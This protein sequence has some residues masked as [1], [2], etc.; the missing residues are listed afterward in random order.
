[1]KKA[2][3]P[4][5]DYGDI[6][7]YISIDKKQVL[8]VPRT[9]KVKEA[10]IWALLPGWIKNNIDLEIIYLSKEEEINFIWPQL[11]SECASKFSFATNWLN[12]AQRELNDGILNINLESKIAYKKL[13]SRNFIQFLEQRI[14]YYTESE[15]TVKPGNGNFVRDVKIEKKKYNFSS[16]DQ[17]KNKSAADG[18]NSGTNSIICGQKINRDD[19]HSLSQIKN[20]KSGV[21]IS[22]Y[23]FDQKK[24]KTRS[25]KTLYTFYL[26]D[27]NDSIT[28]KL[29]VNQNSSLNTRPDTGD[30]VK[31]KGNIKYDTY[32]NELT[33][34][35]NNMQKLP[36]EKRMDETE[37]TRTELHL[38]TRMSAMD[39]VVD[40]EK[41]I[42]TAA[43]WGHSALAI[44]DHGVVQAFPDAYEAGQKH[45]IKIIYGLEAYM[46][47]DGK[48]IIINSKEY[49]KNAAEATYTVFDLETTG[50]KPKNSE[51]IE[52]GAVKIQQGEIIDKF[53]TFVKP[54]N[55]IP[56]QIT[57]ITGI[58]N[59]MVSDAPLIAQVIEDFLEFAD[60]TVLVA[61]NADFDYGFLLK[62]LESGD[63]Y[64]VLDTLGLSRALLPELKS[65]SLK[66]LVS[67]FNI[68]L[69]NHHR[70]LDDA[71][72]TGEIFLNLMLRVSE[73][74]IIELED[75]NR[76]ILESDW[77]DLKP[78]HII[79][80]AKNQK[81]LKTLYKLVSESHI[82]YFHRKPRILKSK[83]IKNKE[84]L[85][86]GS[87]CESGQLF[88]SILEN[89][90]EREIKKLAS[91]Y[92]YLEIQP[93]DNNSFLVPEQVSTREELK[94]INKKIYQ[95]GKKM[96]LPVVATCDVH[97]ENPEDDI[98]RTILQAGQGYDDPEEQAPLY[99]RTTEEMLE[100]FS[101]LG[102]EAAQEVVNANP[103]LINSL[104]DENIKPIPDG[105]FTPKIEGAEKKVRDMCYSRAH[106]LYGD[107]LPKIISE[108]LEKELTSIIDN[109][110]AVIYLISHK[111]VKKSLKDGY[112][113]GSR[114]SVGSSLA[115]YMCEITEVNPL[116][117]HYRCPQCLYSNFEV[118]D[119]GEV[120]VDLPDRECPE[121]GTDLNKS[122][123]D[124]PFEVFLGFEGDKVPDIDLNFSGEYQDT[125]H[126]YTED[127]FGRD[128]V[129]RA[130][131]ISTI[132]DRTAF[133]FVRG[134]MDD[135]GYNYRRAEINRLVKG[136]TGV[137]RTTGQHPGGLMIVPRSM[138][139]HDFCPIQ[140]PAN[141]QDT[142]VRT[143]HFDYH[144]ISGR[145][146]KLDLLG[147]DDPTSLKLLENQTGISPKS[148]P[149]DD[150]DT[151][152]I[153]SSTD[154][155]GVTPDEIGS[156]VGTLG[157]PEFGTGFVRQMLVETRP[158]TFAELVRISGLSHGTD[159]WLNNAQDLIRQ[160]KARLQEVISVRDDIMNFL[161]SRGVE[162]ATAFWIMEHV[163]KGKGL[164][165]KE[166]KTMRE[167]GVPDWY[168]KSCKKIKYMFPKAHAVAYVTMAFRIAYFKVH[169][170]KEF[171]LTYFSNNA[172]DF[173]AHLISQGYERIQQ[174]KEKLENS[175]DLT[176]KDKNILTNLEIVIE[177]L[178]RGIKFSHVDLYR[179]DI[180][181]FS[182]KENGSLLPPLICL[183]GLGSSAAEKIAAS[184]ENG[185]YKSIE[186]MV[187][188]TGISKNVVEAMQE[189]G[190]LEGMPEKNQLSLFE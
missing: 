54:Q 174:E 154:I 32:N 95:L 183:D 92:D 155:L 123:T 83:L 63:R 149:L 119:T 101:Y 159:V 114:G 26:T 80:L 77:K 184:R 85:L 53:S 182:F 25:G 49:K 137:R 177:A 179:S 4:G 76:L 29:F 185:N 122:G 103:E 91:F 7:K 12:R 140:Y 82:S 89:K 87:A 60:N 11:V 14:N 168:I 94:K 39:S 45:G 31:I 10:E 74:E 73:R 171:Y 173:D 138:D 55:K 172:D 57:D 102:N 99:F 50:L 104:I 61:H 148:I 142:D 18:K 81:G 3:K 52:I 33:V 132:A 151:M 147:H 165:D 72:A 181:N 190:V 105:L 22:G 157:I 111:L 66:S 120:G 68:Q 62:H 71:Q 164:T 160:G 84:N 117:P 69:D 40:T 75:I 34:M 139:I 188:R 19:T 141:D 24:R 108:R 15:I 127:L 42:K 28:T 116:P 5:R 2:V 9:R 6:I 169:H 100:E 130:G 36:P 113:V 144:S 125:I 131:T 126:Q 79:I 35:I 163:R 20:E 146:L 118:G 47:D 106:N 1:M 158:T 59:K 64:P 115:A 110:Y 97:F 90:P 128:Y 134:Y 135:F 27:Y 152:S 136:C 41:I 17:N 8:I 178:N 121:C 98:F 67:H 162:P 112:L 156:E 109:G 88:R 78:F 65:H 170:P 133:G 51:I 96:N 13:N 186:D 107:K 187:N 21:I 124:I 166:E 43:E 129:F 23:I 153:F 56:A 93:L 86:F 167:V 37:N 44:T 180:N 30:R 161:I 176:A 143:T 70:A 175:S 145:I 150:E 38:H 48:P 58:T 189:H 46:V 16:S